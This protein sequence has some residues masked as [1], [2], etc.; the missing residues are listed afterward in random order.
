MNRPKSEELFALA[1]NRI[2]GGV[3]SPSARSGA[4][5]TPFF[6]EKEKGANPDADGN[7]Y[8]ASALLGR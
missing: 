3:D 4:S 7:A 5:G 2:P 6:C 8:I 1:Q